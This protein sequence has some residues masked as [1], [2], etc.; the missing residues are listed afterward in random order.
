MAMCRIAL[1]ARRRSNAIGSATRT[2]RDGL[3]NT[4]IVGADDSATARR[5]GRA[6]ADLA[7]ECDEAAR[8]DADIIVVGN[9]RVQSAARM[10]GVRHHDAGDGEREHG[11]WHEDGH[12]HGS[13][14]G[15]AQRRGR[16]LGGP[17][18]TRPQ[19]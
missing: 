9:R 8:L 15:C 11:D 6:A 2:N 13:R 18:R 12:Q 14:H 16:H 1:A 10:H 3:G 17:Q 4:I 5:A 19:L 7:V